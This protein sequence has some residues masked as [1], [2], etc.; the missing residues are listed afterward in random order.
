MPNECYF[1]P[2]YP[3]FLFNENNKWKKLDNIFEDLKE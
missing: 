1:V 2:N 3:K